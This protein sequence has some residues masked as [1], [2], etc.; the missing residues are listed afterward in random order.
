VLVL[1]VFALAVA[2]VLA[3]L[4]ALALVLPV[5][6]IG[7]LVAPARRHVE[8]VGG[9][10]AD[11]VQRS[12]RDVQR[13]A[14]PPVP[15]EIRFKIKR[16]AMTITDLLP[17]VGVLGVG[18]PDTYVLVKCATDYLPTAF[19]EYLQIPRDYRDHCVVA[20]G[21]TPLALLSEQL[22]LLATQIDRIAD[23]VNRV[24]SDKLVANG[25]FLSEKFG[26]G[27]LDIDTG[28]T[29]AD[30]GRQRALT[31]PMTN[32]AF[33]QHA[34]TVVAHH[35]ERIFAEIPRTLRRVGLLFL[36]VAISIPAFLVALIALLWHL[37]S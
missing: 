13:R 16:I 12:L 26:R 6:A 15:I 7:V 21:K 18:S 28:R 35:G 2:G 22:D 25:R 36:V 14:L 30:A 29:D 24:H 31:E 32:T 33:A 34:R 37:G 5:Y 19:Q 1:A 4:V 17:R 27:A 20:D 3:P 23:H 8:V 11:E 9:V 10:D